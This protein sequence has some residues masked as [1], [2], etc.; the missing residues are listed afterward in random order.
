MRIILTFLCIALMAST[1]VAHHSRTYFQLDRQVEVKG[2]ITKVKWRNPHVRYVVESVNNRGA[3]E[4]WSM[5]G[6]TPGNYEQY[7]W[8]ESSLKI[9][10][11]VTFVVYPNSKNGERPA[12]KQSGLLNKV[13]KSDGTELPK[14]A[15]EERASGE[16]SAEPESEFG[17]SGSKDFSGNWSYTLILDEIKLLGSEPPQNWPLTSKGQKLVEAF[18]IDS[19]PIFECI[20]AGAPRM[21]NYLYDRK[22]TRYDDRIEIISEATPSEQNRT[23]WLDGRDKPIAYKENSV[24]FSTGVFEEDG[25]LLVTTDGFAAVR[26]GLETGIDSSTEKTLIERYTLANGSFTGGMRMIFSFT[27]TDPVYLTEPVKVYG[28]YDLTDDRKYAEFKCDP[29]SASAHLEFN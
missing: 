11:V 7:G 26:W 23:I 19:D 22:W 28:V 13:I 12:N 14:K 5:D 1:A 15:E 4:T 8:F 3:S 24:G 16:E 10:D 29:E 17:R 2:K 18:D 20:E 6:Q 21:I 27:V 25:S 9:G